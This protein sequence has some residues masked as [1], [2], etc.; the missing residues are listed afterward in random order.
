VRGVEGVADAQACGLSSEGFELPGDVQHSVFIAGDDG[1][2]RRIEGGEACA[3][4][5]GLEK[6]ADFFFG[7]LEGDHGAAVVERLH[8]HCARGD[9][10]AGVLERKDAAD[11]CGDELANGV[12]EEESGL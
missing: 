5:G 1:G 12:S 6:V 10:G 7:G 4:L 3:S 2:Q 11:V 8:E 9:E